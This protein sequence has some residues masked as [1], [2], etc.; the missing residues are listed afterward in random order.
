MSVTPE[1]LAQSLLR[2]AEA[3]E[4]V[5]AQRAKELRHLVQAWATQGAARGDFRAAWLIGSLSKGNWG[6]ASDVDVV[7]D[8]LSAPEGVTWAE[9]GDRLACT[10]DL[11]RL[12]DL[13]AD[14]KERVL[15]EGERLA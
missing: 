8:G 15:R 7:V 14:F 5:H 12:E 4:Q 11:L 10:V 9:L 13:P 3:R 2:R 1:Q 6:E